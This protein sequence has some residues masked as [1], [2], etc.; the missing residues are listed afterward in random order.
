MSK[1]SKDQTYFDKQWLTHEVYGKWVVKTKL[2]TQYRCKVCHKTNELPNMG[3]QA[4]K[5]HNGAKHVENMR[6]MSNFFSS[7]KVAQKPEPEQPPRKKQATLDQ[8]TTNTVVAEAEIR[9]ILQCVNSGYSNSLNSRTSKLFAKMFPDSAIAQTYS[10]GE[11]KIR[12]SINCGIGPHFKKILMDNI[13]NSDC[14]VISFDESLNKATQTSE[15]DM[16]VRY[17]DNAQK[18]VCTRYVTSS[19]LGHCKRAD[20]FREFSL[21]SVQLSGDKL[22]QISMDGPSTNW[23]FYNLVV[24]DRKE[25]GLPQLINIGSC[26]LHVI[27]GSFKTGAEKTDW[28]LKKIM[29]AAHTILHNMPARREDYE[30]H[31]LPNISS[32]IL[33]R[34]VD[35][36]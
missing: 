32:P 33:W 5:E 24:D 4:I 23:K 8:T 20:L 27:H 11:D 29:K 17:F 19:F 25:K 34:Q 2:N 35:R 18:K 16:L 21:F 31:W 13:K 6:K 36:R 15:M 14:Y 26:G 7:A 12:Y 22:I 9:W 30:R 10:L 3:I 28:N 1:E